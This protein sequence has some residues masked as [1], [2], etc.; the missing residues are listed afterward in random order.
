MADLERVNS[1]SHS[2]GRVSGQRNHP[3]GWE[4]PSQ[5]GEFRILSRIGSGGMGVVYEA[6]QESLGRRVALKVLAGRDVKDPLLLE[7]FKREAQ[8]ASALH[9]TSVVPVFG[10]GQSDG[11]YYYAMQFIAGQSLDYLSTSRNHPTKLFHPSLNKESK[12][13]YRSVSRVGGQAADALARGLIAYVKTKNQFAHAL[14]TTAAC[15]QST[16]ASIQV[17]SRPRPGRNSS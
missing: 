2:A 14:A 10:I 7:R 17:C 11:V 9:H 16:L 8:A 5:L 6:I 1:D 3:S 12:E 15:W 4:L 13:F